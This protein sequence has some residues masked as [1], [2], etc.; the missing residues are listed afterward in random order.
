MAAAAGHSQQR[1]AEGNEAMFNRFRNGLAPVFG[2]SNRYL[3]VQQMHYRVQ[4]P[5]QSARTQNPNINH[6]T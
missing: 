4:L 1:W 6:M 5:A 3:P 2:A